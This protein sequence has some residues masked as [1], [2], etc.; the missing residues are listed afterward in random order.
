MVTFP[1]GRS[2]PVGVQFKAMAVRLH[3][4]LPGGVLIV[5]YL[6]AGEC[7]PVSAMSLLHE[8]SCH[9]AELSARGF[10]WT[11][12]GDF[13]M[14]RDMLGDLRWLHSLRGVVV[15]AQDTAFRLSVPG[16]NIDM[17]MIP[18][19]LRIRVDLPI[20]GRGLRDIP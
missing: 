1:P 7:R 4:G 3:W 6:V 8:V 10:S 2:G 12:R 11:M 17:R 5:V 20:R 18:E 13:Y 15:R 19:S 9:A 14:E 16:S